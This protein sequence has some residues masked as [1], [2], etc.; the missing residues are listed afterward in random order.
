MSRDH[1]PLRDI[2]ADMEDP[3]ASIVGRWTMFTELS[4][5]NALIKSVKILCSNLMSSYTYFQNAFIV[6]IY[7]SLFLMPR[8]F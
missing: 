4:P 1:P 6:I 2:T 5:V 8:F 3:A 7:A